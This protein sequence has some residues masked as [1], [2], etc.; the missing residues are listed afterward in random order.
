MCSILEN[1]GLFESSVVN[2]VPGGIIV[3]EIAEG[4]TKLLNY[5]RKAAEMIGY[6]LEEAEA[7][8][9]TEI[10]QFIIEKDRYRVMEEVEKGLYKGSI[11]CEFQINHRDGTHPW[12]YFHA[13]RVREI[14][15][16]L[17]YAAVLVDMTRAKEAELEAKKHAAHSQYIYEHDALTGLYRKETFE[18]KTEEL[19]KK[20]PDEDFVI[21]KWDAEHFKLINELSGYEIGNQVLMNAAKLL[22]NFVRRRGVAGRIGADQ[23]ISCYP[24]RNLDMQ[25]SLRK[26]Q[27]MLE[28][29]HLGYEVKVNAGIYVIQDKNEPVDFMCDKAALALS[30]IEGKYMESYAYYGK[31]MMNNMM[32]EQ[33]IKNVM[34]E[35]LENEQFKVY[36]QPK[37]DVTTGKVVGGE[38][39]VRWERP[40]HGFVKPEE[41]IPFFEQSGFI[42]SMDRYIWKKVAGYLD[43]CVRQGKK[44]L[45]I[46][47]NA[48]RIDF[49]RDN[50]YEHFIDL[51]KEYNLASKYLELE[52]TESA[53][54][55][56]EDII[57]TTLEQL[58]DAGVTIL[59]DDFGSGYSSFNMMKE[60]PVD[61]LKLDMVFLKDI[62]KNGRGKTIVKHM[63]QLA[64][65]LMIPVIA[66]G[67]ETKEHVE[68]LQEIGCDY[69]QGYYFSRPIPIE[70]YDH[71][72]QG[73]YAKKA[74]EN[75]A[76]KYA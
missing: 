10:D 60:A 52:V 40:G 2:T 47:V 32:R 5:N 6:T 13:E 27:E 7:K 22:M 58:Q 59:I 9:I 12:V 51:L 37:F 38:A 42:S 29:M 57:Y 74:E 33:E 48:S 39:L 21:V 49:Y 69:A 63:V 15:N 55:T 70:E 71:M 62:D 20:Y 72:V 34:R 43:D 41:F 45:P 53:Y 28:G 61:V 11:S 8:K 64:N 44:V 67:V 46:S 31:K 68:L 65:E 54:A 66:E 76:E 56:D 24:L 1:R 4:K 30:S 35:A 19:L 50:L 36:V 14:A 3:C 18:K 75:S 23:F 17:I 16:H 25:R 73:V 26:V